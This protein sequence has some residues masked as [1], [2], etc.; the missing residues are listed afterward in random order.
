MPDNAELLQT[1]DSRSQKVRP[2]CIVKVKA[3]VKR[4]GYARQRDLGLV[5]N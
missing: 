3:A 1:R 2:D 5:K 4:E